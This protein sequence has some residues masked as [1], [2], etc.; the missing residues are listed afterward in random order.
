MLTSKGGQVH[1]FPAPPPSTSDA[2]LGLPQPT[3]THGDPLTPLLLLRLCVLFV[4]PVEPVVVDRRFSN[5]V[6]VGLHPAVVAMRSPV[7]YTV[8]LIAVFRHEER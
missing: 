3:A 2:R 1:P 7:R 6:F 8:V 4:L 5:P